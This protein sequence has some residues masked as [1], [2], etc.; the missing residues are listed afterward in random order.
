MAGES[1]EGKAACLIVAKAEKHSFVKCRPP[2][3]VTYLG[4][5]VWIAAFAFLSLKR[6]LKEA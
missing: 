5:P 3:D 2:M 6:P 1:W 4:H